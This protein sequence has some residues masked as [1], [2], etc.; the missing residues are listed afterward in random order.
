MIGQ[1]AWTGNVRFYDEACQQS[2][3]GLHPPLD[4]RHLPAT[5]V[6]YASGDARGE[7]ILSGKGPQ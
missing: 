6:F 1:A 4:R 5:R 7:L 2:L 3:R